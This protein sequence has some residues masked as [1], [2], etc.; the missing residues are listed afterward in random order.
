MQIPDYLPLSPW[1]R[2]T[3]ACRASQSVGSSLAWYQ[4]KPWQAPKLLIYGA[5]T[6]ATSIPAHFS[7]SGVGT[8]FTLK[9]SRVEDEDFGVHY[10]QQA[11]QLPSTVTQPGTQT[12]QLA[13]KIIIRLL[14]NQELKGRGNSEGRC[15]LQLKTRLREDLLEEDA[16][17]LVDGAKGEM[18]LVRRQPGS[19]EEQEDNYQVVENKELKGRGNSEGRCHLQLKTRLREDLLEEDAESLVDGAK[20]EMELVRRQPGSP[21][22]QGIS[23]WLAWYQQKPGK[24]PKLLIYDASS[25]ESGVLSRF[26][27]SGSGTDFTLTISSLESDDFGTYYCQQH[28]SNPPTVLQ[29]RS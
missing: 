21:E 28:N 22:E 25:L 27:G 10:C 1:E 8:D 7:R 29:A 18:E 23:K 14:Q 26:S 4:Q 12:S 11:I 24:A 6:R 2:T 20:G 16:E 19:P 5:S 3:L 9:I 15:H 13:W 17:S